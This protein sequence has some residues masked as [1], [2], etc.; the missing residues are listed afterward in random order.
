MPSKLE[1]K[2]T[3]L[4]NIIKSARMIIVAP[5]IAG[6]YQVPTLIAT[7]Q[8]LTAI[9][10]SLAASATFLLLYGSL[11]LAD[12]VADFVGGRMRKC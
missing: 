10:S 11:L 1:V 12:I 7:G 5:L 2:S 9:K 8:Y 3:T 4:A 6:A